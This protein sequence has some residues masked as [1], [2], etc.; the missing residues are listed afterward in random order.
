MGCC[1]KLEGLSHDNTRH[2]GRERSPASIK[3]EG[4]QMSRT[5]RNVQYKDRNTMNHDIDAMIHDIELKE[6][7][8]EPVDFDD[9]LFDDPYI[10]GDPFHLNEL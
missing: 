4:N 10:H 3:K 6:A 9:D 7:L 1:K 2:T 5:F 8:D